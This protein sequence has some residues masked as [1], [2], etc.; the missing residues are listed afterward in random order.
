MIKGDSIYQVL[1]RYDFDLMRGNEGIAEYINDH[2]NKYYSDMNEAISKKNDFLGSTFIGMLKEKM[3][4]LNELCK[5]IPIKVDPKKS[6][7]FDMA[8]FIS[9]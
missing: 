7:F 4:L 6:F 9:L 3:P 2:L 1:L 8:S 5:D